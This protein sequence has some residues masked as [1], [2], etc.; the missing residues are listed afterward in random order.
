MI[1]LEVSLGNVYLLGVCEILAFD[2]NRAY[3]SCDSPI[4]DSN[5]HIHIMQ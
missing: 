2:E 3:R 4:Y 5:N 1:F